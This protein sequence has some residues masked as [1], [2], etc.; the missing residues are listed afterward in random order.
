MCDEDKTSNSVQAC[1][2]PAHVVLVLVSVRR[3][4][5]V[6]VVH[7]GL[8]G[9][10]VV[11]HFCVAILFVNCCIRRCSLY[12]NVGSFLPPASTRSQVSFAPNSSIFARAV[13]VLTVENCSCLHILAHTPHAETSGSTL[14]IW[15]CPKE[16]PALEEKKESQH[17]IH[18]VSPF[19]SQH[20]AL[21]HSRIYVGT[22]M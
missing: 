18:A 17:G 16:K 10:L 9:V 1:S 19:P 2:D 15:S 20:A 21:H 13:W 14:A 6:T 8:E 4:R 5:R 22:A 11:I 3:L 7:I 12:K